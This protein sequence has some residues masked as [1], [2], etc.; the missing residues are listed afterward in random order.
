MRKLIMVIVVL[1]AVSGCS[2]IDLA[3]TSPADGATIS[4]NGVT[5]TGTVANNA[6]TGVTINGMAASLYI[7]QSAINQSAEH[8]VA[9]KAQFAVNNVPLN[10]GQ[11]TIVVTAT[12]VNGTST[13]KTIKVNA[14]IPGN[15]IKLSSYPDSGVAPME[16]RLRIDGSFSLSNPTITFTGPG[17]VEKLACD[18]PDE[19]KYR[20]MTEGIYYFTVQATNSAGITCSDTIA[21]TVLPLELMDALLRSKWNGFKNALNHHNVDEA[22][23]NFASGSQDT[24][25]QMYDDMRPILSDVVNELNASTINFISLDNRTAIYEIL[26]TREGTTYSFQLEFVKDKSGLWKIQKF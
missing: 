1:M 15:F 8:K 19:Y 3:I 9:P 5:V 13:K 18:N 6:E 10:A 12:D 21:V 17:G 25:K 14:V 20:I 4:G 26:A 7:S 11:N 16:I 23:I 22:I 2:K 24:Y